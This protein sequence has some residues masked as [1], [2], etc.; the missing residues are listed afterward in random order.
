MN[1]RLIFLVAFL[2]LPYFAH[3]G[4]RVALIIGNDAYGCAP[5]DNAVS[6]SQAVAAMLVSQLGF[7]EEDIVYAENVKRLELFESFKKLAENA[8]IALF[9]YAGHGMESLDGKENF[10]I[11]ID[12]LIVSKDPAVP[13]V[14]KS[15]AALR[16][17]GVSLMAKTMGRLPRLFSKCCRNRVTT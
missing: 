15:E 6:D 12:A 3:S 17:D 16:A 14:A 4:D 2:F 1:L 10:L 11:P 8:K 5:L 13:T 7:A 9:F